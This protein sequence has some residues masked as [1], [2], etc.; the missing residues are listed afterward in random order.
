MVIDRALLLKILGLLW[1]MLACAMLIPLTYGLCVNDS[2][3][4]PLTKSAACVFIVGS[5]FYLLN[6]HVDAQ[7]RSRGAFLLVGLGWF[8]ATVFG[9]LPYYLSGFIASPLD[10]WFESVSGFTTTGAT[11]LRDIE[12][13]PKSLL[14]WRSLTQFLGGMGIIVLSLAILPV[15]GVGGME[16]FRAEAPGPTSDKISARV[17]ETARALWLVYVLFTLLEALLLWLF[18]M[19]PFDA[20]NHAFTTMATGG[21]STKNASIGHYQ[22][23]AIEWIVSVFMFLAG[24]NFILHYHLIRR[25]EFLMFKDAEFRFYGFM[26]F[27]SALCIAF[28]LWGQQ[29]ASFHD[30]VRLASFQVT[31]IMSSTGFASAD[32]LIWGAFAQSLIVLLMVIGGCAGSTGGGIKCVRA[33]MLVKQGYRELYRMVHPKAVLPL[34][35]GKTQVPQHVIQAI[36]GFF[37]LY[38]LLLGVASLALTASD[39]D[40]VTAF[41]SVVSA[42]S[43]IGPGL[44]EVGPALNY[45]GLPDFAKFVLSACMIIGRLEIMTVLVLFTTEYWSS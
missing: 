25:R 41:S 30:S 37:F 23:A 29:Y 26:I 14:L 8:S 12:S 4:L 31:A 28:S 11:I 32:Y 1:L 43:N 13:L 42:L 5:L 15:L 33:M 39:V 40:M 19:S 38:I 6:R 27:I 44:G 3:V 9:A 2:G 7:L 21:F 36:F 16:L 22:S 18:G 45:A 35:L 20:I 24:V 17:S 10:A 34:K